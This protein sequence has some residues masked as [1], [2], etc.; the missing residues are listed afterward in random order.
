M[1]ER[2]LDGGAAVAL[3]DRDKA[4]A[5]ATAG[6]LSARG[7]VIALAVDVSDEAQVDAAQAE[8]ID[9]FG[10]VDILVNNAGVA[11]LNAKVCRLSDRRSGTASCAS[12][13]AASSS[14]A[15]PSSAT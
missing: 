10:P 15:A 3:W 4:L 14:A 9:A 1:A 11:G 13:C 2:L 6:E 7:K 12:I 8:T 5:E